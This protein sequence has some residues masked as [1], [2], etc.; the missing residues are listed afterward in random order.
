MPYAPQY[1]RAH[2]MIAAATRLREA[3]WL[4]DLDVGEMREAA[5]GLIAA[6]ET[7]DLH[8]ALDVLHDLES[9]HGP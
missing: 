5:L 7:R 3:W 2:R 6:T 1:T 4:S 8:T 9:G